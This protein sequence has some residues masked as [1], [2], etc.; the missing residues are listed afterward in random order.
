MIFCCL[1]ILL[2]IVLMW[3]GIVVMVLVEICFECKK[4]CNDKEIEC[5]E[6]GGLLCKYGLVGKVCDLFND[7]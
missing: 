2:V 4:Y 5:K 6:V 7:F 1:V 3:I